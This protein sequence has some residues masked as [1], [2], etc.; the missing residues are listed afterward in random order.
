MNLNVIIHKIHI[1]IPFIDPVLCYC[2]NPLNVAAINANKY[3]QEEYIRLNRD[4]VQ[5]SINISKIL[6]KQ[7]ALLL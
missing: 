1:H 4:Y 2:M 7:A 3:R 6:S 5:A